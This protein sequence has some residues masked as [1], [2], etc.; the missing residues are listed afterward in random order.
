ME[1]RSLDRGCDDSEGHEILTIAWIQVE[2]DNIAYPPLVP[3]EAQ[4]LLRKEP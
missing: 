2:M 3:W 4:G 1:N